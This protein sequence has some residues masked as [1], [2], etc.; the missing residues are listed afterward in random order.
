MYPRGNRLS[1]SL[2]LQLRVLVRKHKVSHISLILKAELDAQY[3]PSKYCITLLHILN[4]SQIKNYRQ[5]KKAVNRT[6][7]LPQ[8]RAHQFAS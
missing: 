2:R 8:G 6:G 5:L 3:I 4:N 7:G 1:V